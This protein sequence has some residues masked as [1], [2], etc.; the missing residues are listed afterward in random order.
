MTRRWKIRLSALAAG[1]VSGLFGGGGGMVFLPLV[2]RC[3][4]EERQAFAVTLAV[5]WPVCALGAG[6]Y[7]WRGAVDFGVLLPCLI[8]G[9]FGGLAGGA[10]MGK[11]PVLWLRRVFAGFLLFA[12]GRYLL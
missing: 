6:V 10:S 9:F 8:G 1:L 4:V 7:L 3:G 5:L 12:G 11:I 2:R